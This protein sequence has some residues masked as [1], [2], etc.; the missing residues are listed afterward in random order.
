MSFTKQFG[1]YAPSDCVGKLIENCS[2][3]QLLYIAK[4]DVK[5]DVGRDFQA[6][7]VFSQ[8]PGFITPIN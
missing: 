4:N 3:L 6:F 8:H 2:Y 1:Y 7:L 5:I